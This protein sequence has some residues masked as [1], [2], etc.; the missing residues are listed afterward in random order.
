MWKQF[1]SQYLK[2]PLLFWQAIWEYLKIFFLNRKKTLTLVSQQQCNK[3]N[4]EQKVFQKHCFWLKHMAS[5]NKCG[6]APRR[7][8]NLLL[9]KLALTKLAP[10]AQEHQ[11]QMANEFGP[12]CLPTQALCCYRPNTSRYNANVMLFKNLPLVYFSGKNNLQ[13]VPPEHAHPSAW[14]R[15]LHSF[16]VDKC[17]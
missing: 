14:W 5:K 1:N 3:R 9:R 10:L 16:A 15:E 17:T 13:E 2:S 6:P 7:Q 8:L 4:R 12:Q 11:E